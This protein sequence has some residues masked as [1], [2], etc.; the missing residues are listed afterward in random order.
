MKHFLIF[1]INVYQQ[2]FSQ[3]LKIILGTQAL[4]RFSPSCSEYAKRAIV[5][6]GIFKGSYLSVLRI[7]SCQPWSKN[8]V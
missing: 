8:Y 1:V 7:L 6:Y 5:R 4:C 3:L 2:I